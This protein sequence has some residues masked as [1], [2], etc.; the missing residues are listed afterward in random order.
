MSTDNIK[1][2]TVYYY[3]LLCVDDCRFG[4]K[5]RYIKHIQDQH[6]NS[7]YICVCCASLFNKL[8]TIK[9]CIEISHRCA[10][11]ANCDIHSKIYVH[12]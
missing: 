6:P 7:L 4:S 9:E 8:H 5:E 10:R 11:C 12:K 3:C 2:K 1:N